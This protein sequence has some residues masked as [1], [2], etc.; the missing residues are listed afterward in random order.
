MQSKYSLA[1]CP[2]WPNSDL[3][4]TVLPPTVS[5]STLAHNTTAKIS[6]IDPPKYVLTGVTANTVHFVCNNGTWV[7]PAGNPECMGNFLVIT[8]TGNV[9][10]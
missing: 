4:Y 5:D 2:Q 10:F 3:S 7:K 1:P 6:C 8:S 9:L